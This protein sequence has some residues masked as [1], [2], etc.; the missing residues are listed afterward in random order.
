MVRIAQ[1]TEVSRGWYSLQGKI[2][3]VLKRE[4]DLPLLIGLHPKLDEIISHRMK[5]D[6][7]SLDII[8]EE[9]RVGFTGRPRDESWNRKKWPKFLR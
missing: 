1:W 6:E 4:R 7:I 3:K 5:G 9:E 8:K 2:M